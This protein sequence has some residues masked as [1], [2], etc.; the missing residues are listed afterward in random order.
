MTHRERVAEL[1]RI[2]RYARHHRFDYPQ[3]GRKVRRKAPHIDLFRRA[4]RG[5]D[6]AGF[7]Y[8]ALNA[9]GHRRHV[10]LRRL[11]KGRIG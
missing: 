8:R 1:R 6:S 5:E 2:T 9:R 4:S 3:F 11:R 7:L 10:L